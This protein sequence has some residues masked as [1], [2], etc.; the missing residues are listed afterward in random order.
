MTAALI[1]ALAS[2]AQIVDQEHD[3]LTWPSSP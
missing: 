1:D 2:L 3:R